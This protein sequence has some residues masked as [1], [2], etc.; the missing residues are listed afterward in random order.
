MIRYRL[1]DLGWFQFEWLVQAA[2]KDHLGLGVE[3]W[4][5]HHDHGRDAWCDDALHFPAK[6]S[7]SDGPFLFQAK[8]VENANAAGARPF[9]RLIAAV[10][11]EMAE[12]VRR[13]A[14]DDAWLNCRHYVLIT[15]SL[16]SPEGRQTVK[17]EVKKS[18]LAAKVH[19]LGGGDICD[20]LD[21]TPAVRRA[22]PQLLSLRD[23]DA[24]LASIV[25]RDIIER[26]TAAIAQARD[27]ASVFIPTGAYIQTWDVLKKHHFAVL[28]GPAEM[29]K[30]A[31]A[32]M[33]ALTQVASGWEAYVCDTPEDFFRA[34]P[35]E[36]SK[37]FIADD[38]FGRTEYDPARGANWEAQ[39]HRVFARLG[40]SHWLIWTSRRHILERARKRLDLQGGASAFPQPGEVVVDASRLTV[41]EKALMLY[42]HSR[43]SLLTH[44]TRALIKRHAV[45]IVSDA[46]FTPERIRRFV[47]EVVPHLV[48][49]PTCKAD[50]KALIARIG[51][52]IQNP[53]ERM[54]K[55][56]QALSLAHKWMLLSLLESE[57]YCTA[58][59]L[60]SRYRSQYADGEVKPKEVLEELSEAFV[61]INGTTQRIV[62]WIHPSY[63]DLVI[64]QLRDGGS[65]KSEFLNR[66]SM[67]GIQLALSA[68]GGATGRLRFPLVTSVNDWDILEGRCL[69]VAR[70]SGTERCAALLTTLTDALDSSIGAERGIL[71]RILKATCR[72]LREKWDGEQIEL[73]APTI[74]SY[75]IAS[76]RTSPMEPM[77]ALEASW[78]AAVER[79]QRKIRDDE[80][81]F[82]LEAGSLD[83]LLV[84]NCV[85]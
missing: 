39:L 26:S 40:N 77:P 8:F 51:H 36:T 61:R 4:G 56:F 60:I 30:S 85:S 82:L 48:A 1:D 24:L 71:Q 7:K 55:S 33:I 15:N 25:N 81:D 73:D 75:A 62:E 46:A 14:D 54:R 21:G 84:L 13:S 63:R 64:E 23:L 22:F 74:T 78:H 6:Q 57:N 35:G 76:E 69:H 32:W 68:A 28:D 80:S 83:D 29:G 67:S 65:L 52:E 41:Q 58:E 72:I 66:M 19:C 31:I 43:N 17:T 10:R 11:A 47:V 45:Q 70:S 12:I 9:P 16:I 5:G 59:N 2:L 27:V 3:S 18:L 49:D 50:A 53:T 79:L 42:R 38:A 34:L 37:I 44:D 20:I